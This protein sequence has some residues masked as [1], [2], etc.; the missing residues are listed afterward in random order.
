MGCGKHMSK[1][2]RND[3]FICFGRARRSALRRQRQRT[4]EREGMG[5]GSDQAWEGHWQLAFS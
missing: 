5:T 1:G 4:M 2:Q 3:W